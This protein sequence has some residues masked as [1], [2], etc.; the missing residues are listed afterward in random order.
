M[1]IK[2]IGGSLAE[3][4]I[5]SGMIH[6]ISDI[7]T[8]TPEDWQKLDKI[9]SKSAHNIITQ[10]QASKNR[11]LVNLVTALG[12]LGVGKNTAALLVNHFG[13][14]DA[15]M[16]AS[17]EDI[18]IIDGIG[19][20]IAEAVYEFFRNAENVKMIEKFR[21]I[22]LRMSEDLPASK[23]ILDGKI[24]V[25]TGTLSSMTREEA[26]ERV[27]SLGGKVTGSVSAKTSY[28]V[29]GEKA[30]SKLKK[31][32]NLNVKILSEQEFLDMI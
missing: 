28:V 29:A 2:G 9:G 27:K 13:K 14:I 24:F 30:G 32:E 17:Q 22:G 21:A 15:M 23:G 7:Y 3:K 26:G 19:P 10:L 31:A 1:N 8:L 12:I 6:A 4:L 25:F 20:V 16:T 11:P 18:A 5:A